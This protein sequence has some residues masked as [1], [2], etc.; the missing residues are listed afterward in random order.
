ML[1]NITTSIILYQHSHSRF[2]K[3]LNIIVLT[4]TFD[5][6]WSIKLSQPCHGTQFANFKYCDFFE[7]YT[8]ERTGKKD[9]AISVRVPHRSSC[10]HK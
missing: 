3:L 5:C 10:I 8:V 7:L 1:L 4:N 2:E 6:V 9:Y